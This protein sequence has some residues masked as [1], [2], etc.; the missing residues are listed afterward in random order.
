[1]KILFFIFCVTLFTIWYK[2]FFLCGMNF[3]FNFRYKSLW[4]D[5]LW[6]EYFVYIFV[7][8]VFEIS[9]FFF[10]FS[11]FYFTQNISQRLW[12]R[13]GIQEASKR[14]SRF[15]LKIDVESIVASDIYIRLRNITFRHKNAGQK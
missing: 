8:F 3:S 15:A 13:N 4:S 6:K 11:I 14:K 7:Y 10:F 12:E 5:Q 9:F 2:V 1:M